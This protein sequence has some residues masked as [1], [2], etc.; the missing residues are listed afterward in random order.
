LMVTALVAIGCGEDDATTEPTDG[1]QKIEVLAGQAPDNGA[2]SISK[3]VSSQAG[4]I[5][6]HR[7]NGQGGPVVPG[8]I[9]K[10]Q[11]STGTNDDV[12]ITL[13]SSVADGEIL[14]AMLHV[15]DG[16]TGVYEFTGGTSPDQPAKQDGAIVM[17][18]F[19]IGQTDPS[20]EVSD[21][22]QQNNTVTI[23]SVSSPE[24]GF[25]VIHASDGN[26]AFANVIGKAAVQAGDNQNVVVTLD[27]G[28]NIV[29]G[30]KLWAMLH[31]D[32]GTEGTY[33]FPGADVPAI[34]E[35]AIV[36]KS[37]I[38]SGEAPAVTVSNQSA[39]DKVMIAS[40]NVQGPAWVVIHR[41]NGS[42]AP[43]VPGIIGKARLYN[44][45]NTNVEIQLDEN[46][47]SGDKL[48]AMLH[49]DTGVIGTYEFDGANGLDLP[50]I[51]NSMIQME[52]F[53]IQ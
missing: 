44:G 1:K 15:D 50:I 35:G 47:S 51:V 4:W 34:F 17:T 6:I 39:T 24:N 41:D 31:Y 22:A 33:E 11:V 7:D 38:I 27:E 9:G 49:F 23:A 28:A 10:A 13:D 42:N 45:S 5:V 19:S 46:V 20:V 40:A 36:M 14:W 21:Q 3:V 18:S 26:G 16:Q 12:K 32:R 53:V 29:D 2:I 43:V 48:W 37:F 30:D 25:I 52:S 8:I